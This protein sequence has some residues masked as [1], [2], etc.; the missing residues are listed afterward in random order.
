MGFFYLITARL[1][2]IFKVIAVKK[3]GTAAKG[4]KN[5]VKINLIRAL[6]C[7]AVS[8]VV[9][10]FSQ[11]GLDRAGLWISLLSGVS[12]AFFLLLWILANAF[13]FASSTF[14]YAW[15]GGT[16]PT[17]GALVIQW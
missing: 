11:S 4:A 15:L 17:I 3:C 16:S 7:L 1:A 10:A 2:G 6:G 14:L 12:N 9:F 8:F 13:P 5:S